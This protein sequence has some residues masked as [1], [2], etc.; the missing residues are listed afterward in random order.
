MIT[1]QG[2]I[3]E[4]N[5]YK[6]EFESMPWARLFSDVSYHLC[7]AIEDMEINIAQNREIGEK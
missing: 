4:L 3:N 2:A 5:N 6:K 7:C 1:I